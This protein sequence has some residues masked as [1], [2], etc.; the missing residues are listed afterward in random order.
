MSLFPTM[1][2]SLRPSSWIEHQLKMM[3]QMEAA[4]NSAFPTHPSFEIEWKDPWFERDLRSKD[5][6]TVTL[7]VKNFAPKEI[8]VKTIDH[9]IIVEG[10]H[11]EKCEQ[12]GHITRHFIKTFS[13]PEGHEAEDVV[14]SLSSNGILTITAPNKAKSTGSEE[15]EIPI[16]VEE[17][18]SEIIKK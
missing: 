16:S 7:D 9:N 15:R 2:R 4:V 5:S 3:R 6:F 12:K 17:K 11:E 1:L 10:K 8:T 18:S 14:S 13:L